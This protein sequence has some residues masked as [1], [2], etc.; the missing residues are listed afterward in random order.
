MEITPISQRIRK[1]QN[2]KQ[3]S[4]NRVRQLLRSQLQLELDPVKEGENLHDILKTTLLELC[5]GPMSS[6]L[7]T[8][9]G[10]V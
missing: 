8:T 10:E 3:Q 9:S 6:M 2:L 4:T 7:E 1:I 5:M